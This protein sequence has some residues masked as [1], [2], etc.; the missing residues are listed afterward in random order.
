MVF[1][2]A[3]GQKQKPKTT[4]QFRDPGWTKFDTEW[5]GS[6]IAKLSLQQTVGS[7]LST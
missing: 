7:K 6:E 4:L 2:I 5:D 3:S 1:L